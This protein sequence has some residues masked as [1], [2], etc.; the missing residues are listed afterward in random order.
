MLSGVATKISCCENIFRAFNGK[1]LKGDQAASAWWVDPIEQGLCGGDVA[2]FCR[3][4]HGIDD[5]LCFGYAS[6]I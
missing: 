1:L 3:V 4:D 6:G 2:F 5:F